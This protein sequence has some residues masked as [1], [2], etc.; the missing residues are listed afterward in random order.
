[1]EAFMEKKQIGQWGKK[2]RVPLM[3]LRILLVYLIV[4]LIAKYSYF[5]KAGMIPTDKFGLGIVM[6]LLAYRFFSLTI[7][8]GMLV[9]WMLS[10]K[11]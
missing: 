4:L 1:M 11:K 10:R 5:Y 8:P 7:A 6:F 3:C 2:C 9:F